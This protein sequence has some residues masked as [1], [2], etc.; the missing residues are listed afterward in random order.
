M[1]KMSRMMMDMCMPMCMC[2]LCR[3]HNSDVL[4]E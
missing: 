2:M 1:K 3:A 4:P